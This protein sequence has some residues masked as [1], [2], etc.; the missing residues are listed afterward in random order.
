[1]RKFVRQ[2]SQFLAG[3]VIAL[4]ICDRMIGHGF[5]H[6][7]GAPIV[8]GE[9]QSISR[10][11][12]NPSASITSIFLGDSVARQLFT[13]GSE[14]GAEA[15]FLTSNQA[16]SVAGQCYL[17]EESLSSFP[18][19]QDVYLI[20]IPGCFSNDLP[21]E[22]SHDYFC[23]YFHQPRQVLE[24]FCVKRDFELSV[25]HVGRLLL[26]NL[27]TANSN[28]QP[29]MSTQP[30]PAR[31]PT[32]AFL[33]PAPGGGEPLLA[34]LS[35]YFGLVPEPH[36]MPAG[37]YGADLSPVSRYFLAKMRADCA[38]RGVR[39]HVLPDPLST[40]ETFADPQH[41]YDAPPIRVDPALLVD[42]VHFR[43]EHVLEYRAKM[44]E[45]YRLPLEE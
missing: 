16:V 43:E 32:A 33:A 38:A 29:L 20:Y 31:H 19:L 45:V 12:R 26:P 34:L 42:P 9:V 15:R 3:L 27:M 7:W 11:A 2:S 24:V 21:N 25:A 4:M 39:L 23:G 18:N 5:R 17:L 35:K 14:C 10:K 41:I 30:T 44:I 28:W 8:G 40:A 37:T 1:M 36:V 6:G 22:L 13:P